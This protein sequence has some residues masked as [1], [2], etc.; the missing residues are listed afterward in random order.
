MFTCVLLTKLLSIVLRAQ[1]LCT[2][3]AVMGGKSL[4][5]QISEKMVRMNCCPKSVPRTHCE[6]LKMPLHLTQCLSRF[7]SNCQA[8]CYSCC[9]ASCPCCQDRKVSCNFS[10]NFS[11][12]L[13]ASLASWSSY[14]IWSVMA[15][16]AGR[17]SQ[18]GWR[19]ISLV[20][21]AL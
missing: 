6:R 12:T 2:T 20:N 15:T 8:G 21:N 9:S 17:P 18:T 3:A 4:A 16:K 19:F 10:R 7:R 13:P 1:A 5:S 11:R 14:L